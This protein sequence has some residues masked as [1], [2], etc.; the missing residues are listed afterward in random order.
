MSDESSLDEYVGKHGTAVADV[1]KAVERLCSEVG[2]PSTIAYLIGLAVE[3]IST[4]VKSSDF[5]AISQKLDAINEFMQRSKECG[6]GKSV[7]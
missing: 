2:T 5:A 7:H 3:M 1:A 6:T 4:T